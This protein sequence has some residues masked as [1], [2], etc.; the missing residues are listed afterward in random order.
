MMDCRQV[1][2]ILEADNGAAVEAQ[3]EALERHLQACT[4]CRRRYGHRFGFQ[5][6]QRLGERDQLKAKGPLENPEALEPVEFKDLPVRFEL[7][8]NGTI[9]DVKLVEPEVD[10]PLPQDAELK[11]I[12]E[13]LPV[14]VVVF[15]FDVDRRRYILYLRNRRN[16]RDRWQETTEEYGPEPRPQKRV[17]GSVYT[18]EIFRR[19]NLQA[20]IAMARGKA[21]VR[22]RYKPAAV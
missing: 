4:G 13:D 16:D 1:R 14:T 2:Q 22:I 18:R 3:K 6:A 19:H 5:S 11:I 10:V 17:R 7:H 20:W 8:L 15:R 12:R 21:R 9:E